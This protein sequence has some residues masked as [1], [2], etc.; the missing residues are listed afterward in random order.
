[1]L[2]HETKLLLCGCKLNLCRPCRCNGVLK[3]SYIFALCKTTAC[4]ADLSVFPKVCSLLLEN[5]A[6]ALLLGMIFS[7]TVSFQ[8]LIITQPYNNSSIQLVSS[9]NG[10][11]RLQFSNSSFLEYSSWSWTSTSCAVF[12]KVT[13]FFIAENILASKISFFFSS[14]F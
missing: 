6:L 1:M 4:E 2:R 12:T 11:D 9:L 5:N 13:F 3:Y 14:N 7:I 8:S 10:S